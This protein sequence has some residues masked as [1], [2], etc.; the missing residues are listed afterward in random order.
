MESLE[1]E[2]EERFRKVSFLFRIRL[3]VSRSSF[4]ITIPTALLPLP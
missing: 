2:D 1:E 4:L 3:K